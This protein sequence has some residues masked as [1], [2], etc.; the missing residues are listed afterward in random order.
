MGVRFRHKVCEQWILE[1]KPL[2]Y[3]LK[4]LRKAAF[5]PEFS[6]RHDAAIRAVA[7]GATP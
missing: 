7:K 3:V 2:E 6:K 5:D 4:N 1:A